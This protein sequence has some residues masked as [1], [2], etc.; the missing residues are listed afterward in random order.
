MKTDPIPIGLLILLDILVPP[1][2]TLLW[3]GMA[4]GWAGLVQFGK[5]S[6]ATRRR[7]KWEFWL[8]L[9]AAYILMFAITLY[10]LLL[11]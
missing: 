6:G 1:I 3:W 8:I 10:G 4:R 5:V 7:Q 2:G 11:R 9:V